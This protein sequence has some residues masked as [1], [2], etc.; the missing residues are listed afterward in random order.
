[1]RKSGTDPAHGGEAAQK[2]AQTKAQRAKERE[3][4][5]A[6]RGDG[7][8]ERERFEAETLPKLASVTIPTIQKAIGCSP[9]YASLIRRGLYIPHPMHYDALG[10]LVKG[11]QAASGPARS[12]IEL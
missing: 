9:R 6:V 8:D 7:A 1:M 12:T 10:G 5:E 4:W 11:G 2:R 3:Q